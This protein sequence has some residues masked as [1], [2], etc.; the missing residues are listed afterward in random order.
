M[1]TDQTVQLINLLSKKRT[2]CGLSVAEVARRA[3]INVAAVWRIEQGRIATPK[4][5]SLIAIGQ[6][7]GIPSIDLFTIVGWLKADDLPSLRIYLRSKYDDVPDETLAEVEACIA[8]AMKT[9]WTDGADAA[10]PKTTADTK[11][12]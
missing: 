9:D 12:H 2:E 5:E 1:N 4:A 11:E 7:L 6:V 8:S 3:H 10:G